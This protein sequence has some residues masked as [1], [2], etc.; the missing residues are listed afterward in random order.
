MNEVKRY[1]IYKRKNAVAQELRDKKF[2]QRV[3]HPKKIYDR[4]K[5]RRKPIEEDLSS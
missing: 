5:D 2:R 4:A 1:K 3:P